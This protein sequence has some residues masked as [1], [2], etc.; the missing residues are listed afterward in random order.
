MQKKLIRFI[1]LV[2]LAFLYTL[3]AK[4][5]A[6]STTDN[7]I[8]SY[9]TAYPDYVLTLKTSPE[10]NILLGGVLSISSSKQ[11]GFLMKLKE[12]GTI[13]WSKEYEYTWYSGYQE[14]SIKGIEIVQ[15]GY[16]LVSEPGVIF[17]VDP[18]GNLVW[19]KSITFVEDSQTLPVFFEDIA[20]LDDNNYIA[21]GGNG[22][23]YIVWITENDTG[24]F[25]KWSKKTN[26]V[27][28][29]RAV[30]TTP[31][32][33]FVT[34]GGDNKIAIF[35]FNQ[36]GTLEWGKTYQHCE[37]N[38]DGSEY[39]YAEG[40]DIT[41]TEDGY[42]VVGKAY[43]NITD[44]CIAVLKLDNTGN[45]VWKKLYKYDTYGHYQYDLGINGKLKIVYNNNTQ[46][47]IITAVKQQKKPGLTGGEITV[48]D[49]VVF[50]ISS[51]DG[52]LKR[53]FVYGNGLDGL[54]EVPQGLEVLSDGSV[55]IG[56]WTDSYSTPETELSIDAWLLKLDQY[57]NIDSTIK[58]EET[59]SELDWGGLNATNL[60]IFNLNSTNLSIN[61]ASSIEVED[62]SFS[63]Y[64][65]APAGSQEE[66]N[67]SNSKESSGFGC[68]IS[69]GSTLDLDL[70]L[71][72]GLL[73][74][75][76]LIGIHR[77]ENLLK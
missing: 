50:C 38:Y 5:I 74:F 3:Y 9:G 1:L 34:V 47:V 4:A 69:H 73:L 60:S 41:V 45:I 46:E 44:D 57:A 35:K 15:D 31:D 20:K 2:F 42:F 59:V 13:L 77:K 58:K 36:N 27:P 75:K 65:W 66:E 24:V 70:S 33:G 39:C 76:I 7:Y 48:S 55:L 6:Y 53:A 32:G 67:S 19:G 49:I 22:D 14:C 62:V 18:T 25:L 43:C 21:V 11:D 16:I 54:D 52:S 71:L 26:I 64:T 29:F 72:I 61:N 37:P 12:D 30:K 17:K 10:G 63:S 28:S 68:T 56:G 40:H 8:K 51:E 23:G